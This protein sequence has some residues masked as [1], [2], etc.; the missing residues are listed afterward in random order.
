MHEFSQTEQWRGVDNIEPRLRL[1][2]CLQ[3][4]TDA[5]ILVK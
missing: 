3:G 2:W 4:V 1:F 5:N